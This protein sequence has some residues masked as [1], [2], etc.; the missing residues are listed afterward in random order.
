M[1][2]EV[3]IIMSFSLWGNQ[4]SNSASNMSKYTAGD[5]WSQDLF[6]NVPNGYEH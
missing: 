2:Y 5:W 3:G 1:P 4:L 6:P